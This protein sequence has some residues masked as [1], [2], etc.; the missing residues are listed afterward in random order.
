[1][2]GGL[3]CRSGAGEGL[4]GWLL[5]DLAATV[6][7]GGVLSLPSAYPAFSLLPCPLSPSPFPNGEGEIYGYFMQG[8]PPLASPAFNRLRHLQ[9]FSNLNP[10]GGLP[11]WSPAD[12]AAV[13]PDG[14]LAFLSPA[15]PAF[16]LLPYPPIPL[17]RWG[18]GDQGYFMQGAP[19]LASPAFNRLR[20]SQ[21]LPY[22][23]PHGVAG[24][25]NPDSDAQRE[26]TLLQGKEPAPSGHRLRSA[27]LCR[28]GSALGDARGEAPCIR[29]QK[30]SP[31]P[32]G[33][34][35][36]ASAGGGMGAAKQAKG[37]VGR[38]QTRQVPRRARGSPPFPC[39]ARVQPSGMQGA[40][41]LA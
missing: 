37:T 25:F 14:G 7:G 27:S 35:R 24:F 5:A 33:E 36:S 41:P 12:L 17:P 16:S 11:G 20:H 32:G 1:M 28:P 23:Y 10:T 39:A 9:T 3:P 29:K 4:P 8:A 30:I 13:V 6:P 38:Q 26:P 15:N 18:R 34:E 31:F 2:G 19:P 21:S 40:K 22:R